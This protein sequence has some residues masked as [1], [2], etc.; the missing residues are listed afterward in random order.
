MDKSR[1]VVLPLGEQVLWRDGLK[2]S[3]YPLT[4]A[5]IEQ[6]ECLLIAHVD[7]VNAGLAE[8]GTGEH[9]EPAENH[10]QYCVLRDAEGHRIVFLNAFCRL[11]ASHVP[12]QRTWVE[13]EDGGACY[14]QVLF[15]L[16]TS[17]V[18]EFTMNGIG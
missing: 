13:V 14:F 17:T 5:D 8:E 18:L 16:T 4:H 2:L 15:D 11:P 10:R 3:E 1:Y 9:I 6:A 12:W 7:V